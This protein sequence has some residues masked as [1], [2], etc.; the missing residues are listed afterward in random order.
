MT[1]SIEYIYYS[2][3]FLEWAT[4]DHVIMHM[5]FSSGVTACLKVNGEHFAHWL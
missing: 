4:P 3:L 2:R 5:K 1:L